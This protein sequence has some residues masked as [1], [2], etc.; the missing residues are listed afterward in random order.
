[1]RKCR[2]W[3]KKKIE[4]RG[5]FREDDTQGGDQF[6]GGSN[7]GMLKGIRHFGSGGKK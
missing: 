6:K 4:A 5:G 1:V 7:K 2:E 3:K